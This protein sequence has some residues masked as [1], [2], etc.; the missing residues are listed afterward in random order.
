VLAVFAAGG[1]LSR[2]SLGVILFLCLAALV[3]WAPPRNERRRWLPARTTLVAAVAVGLATVAAAGWFYLRNLRL[4]GSII[5]G[6]PEWAAENL[7]R[8]PRPILDMLL[9]P[10]SLE[11]LYGL[12][13]YGQL[14]PGVSSLV[15]LVLPLLLGVVT[16]ARG[17]SSGQASRRRERHAVA[18][19]LALTVGVVLVQ[20]LMYSA[21]GGGLNPRYLMPILLP[22]VALMALGLLSVE[23]LRAVP[24]IVWAAL[25]Q[26]D[27]VLFV[28]AGL[29][30]PA[31]NVPSF[32]GAGLALAL[33]GAGA[34]AVACTAVVRGLRRAG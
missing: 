27:F 7:G 26:V 9:D 2:A 10:V 24:V 14:P 3:L 4:T 30:G 21:G 28:V 23:R 22:L 6:D 15:L 1:V 19:F 16:L 18:G 8:E 31:T 32:P 12:F 29:D 33:A 25:V 5:G 34:M 17:W 13:S 20:Q 11:R